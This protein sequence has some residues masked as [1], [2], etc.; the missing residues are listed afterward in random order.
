[1]DES[2]HQLLSDHGL[3]RFKAGFEAIGLRSVKELRWVVDANLTQV[4]LKDVEMSKFYSMRDAV[5]ETMRT[6]ALLRVCVG[7]ENVLWR[8]MFNFVTRNSDST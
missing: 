8:F 7:I 5:M 2:F 1:M 4:G 6:K 3:G